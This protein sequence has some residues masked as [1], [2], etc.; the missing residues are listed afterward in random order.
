M[1]TTTATIKGQVTIPA[2]LR[3]KLNIHQGTKIS[4]REQ[5]GE[6]IMEPLPDDPLKAGRGI[7]KTKGKAIE[8]LLADRAFEADK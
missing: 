6:I 7:L 1:T 3:K 8:R 5:G 2:P 4:V